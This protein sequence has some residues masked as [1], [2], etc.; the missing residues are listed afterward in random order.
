MGSNS[1]PTI[2]IYFNGSLT[3][4][5]EGLINEPFA[6]A[7]Q[8]KEGGK[9]IGVEL[10]NHGVGCNTAAQLYTIQH[11]R[12]GTSFDGQSD[13]IMVMARFNA[14]DSDEFYTKVAKKFDLDI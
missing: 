9:I 7:R 4:K 12:H 8:I 14:K 6:G 3:I 10:P 2:T 5:E 1:S 11:A 13:F